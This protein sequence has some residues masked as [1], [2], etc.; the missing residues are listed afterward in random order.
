MSEMVERIARALCID[1]H[2]SSLS[3]DAI[4]TCGPAREVG[5]PAWKFFEDRARV[6]IAAMR[7]P[8]EAM[9]NAF[10]Q[11][12]FARAPTARELWQTMIDAALE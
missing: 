1:A 7:E 11:H 2:G 4:L 12:R 3:P 6:A 8:T 5:Q 9:R 10:A